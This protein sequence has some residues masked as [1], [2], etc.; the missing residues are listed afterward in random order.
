MSGLGGPELRALGSS[1]GAGRSRG[2]VAGVA[3]RLAAALGAP[4]VRAHEWLVL[5]PRDR[6]PVPP[7]VAFPKPPK[8]PGNIFIYTIISSL[9]LT[10]I[11][12]ELTSTCFSVYLRR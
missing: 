10:V 6:M 7:H 8:A 4:P 2:P 5:T 1:G 3:L 11:I 9:K 12:F